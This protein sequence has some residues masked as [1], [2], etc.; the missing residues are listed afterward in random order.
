MSRPFV[1]AAAAK[2]LLG[3]AHPL[4]MALD[5]VATATRQLGAV[6]AAACGALVAS[7]AGSTFGATLALAAG[8][9]AIVFGV[10]LLGARAR[11]RERAR[12]AIIAGDE[13]LPFAIIRRQR[14]R[15]LKPE[16]R[17][18]LAG[19]YDDLAQRAEATQTRVV[20]QGAADNTQCLALTH[21]LRG[22]ARLLRG[23]ALDAAG[24]ALAEQLLEDRSSPLYG[25]DIDA[26]REALGRIAP[27]GGHRREAIR[28][29]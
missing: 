11:A 5:D 6:A 25:A 4:A 28:G 20:A 13:H 22:V 8:F 21:D 29:A 19:M 23:S 17:E 24:V 15:L 27:I 3:A 10:R 2:S 26:L 1:N 12:E 16:M 7:A 9:L 18:L 14:D